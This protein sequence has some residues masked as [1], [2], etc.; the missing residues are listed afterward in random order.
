MDH[1][2]AQA[3]RVQPTTS[4]CL[5][6]ALTA[7]PSSTTSAANH[8]LVHGMSS[9]KH[10]Q[11]TGSRKLQLMFYAPPDDDYLVNRLVA[12]ATA[13]KTYTQRGSS[14]LQR[15]AH[16]ELS[17]DDDPNGSGKLDPQ[18]TLAFSI[19]QNSTVFMQFKSWRESYVAV[20]LLVSQE[21]YAKLFMRCLELSQQK[22]AFDKFG[23]Y[24]SH[25]APS[26]ML[27]RRTREEHGTFCSRIIVEVLQEAGIGGKAV[28]ALEPATTTPCKLFVSVQPQISDV[29]SAHRKIVQGKK[30]SKASALF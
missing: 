3:A 5:A 25:F 22:I 18:R 15:F 17:F 14:E 2:L 4:V 11:G 10:T 21:Q 26:A 30:T 1:V 24:A 16:V 19:V 23:M 20:T 8:A 6:R 29:C 7:P 9:V 13:E 27:T 28:Q 12:W